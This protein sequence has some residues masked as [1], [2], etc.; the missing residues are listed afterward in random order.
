M[1][2]L[3]IYRIHHHF[4]LVKAKAAGSENIDSTGTR[5]NFSTSARE[6][7]Q[8]FTQGR[9]LLAH[10]VPANDRNLDRWVRTKYLNHRAIFTFTRAS[11]ATQQVIIGYTRLDHLVK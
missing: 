8:L 11:V 1:K 6:E 9:E 3:F 5:F 7:K 10:K 4:F 2:N